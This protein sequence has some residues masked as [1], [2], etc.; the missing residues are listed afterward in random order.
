M[1]IR[2]TRI[3]LSSFVDPILHRNHRTRRVIR[4][5]AA[6]KGREI[7]QHNW[8]RRYQQIK[9]WR[10]LP[11]GLWPRRR[12]DGCFRRTTWRR[13]RPTLK[14]RIMIPQQKL[15]VHLG[16]LSK[17]SRHRSIRRSFLQTFFCPMIR[18]SAKIGGGGGQPS[19]GGL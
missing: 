11:I 10:L 13:R 15:A 1:S 17:R 6:R 3:S 9:R 4:R 2:A 12:S 8:P 14:R 7:H 16:L 18:R 5:K 19:S